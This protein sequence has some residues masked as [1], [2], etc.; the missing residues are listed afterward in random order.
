VTHQMMAARIAISI[1]VMALPPG[2]RQA[3]LTA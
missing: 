1:V 3:T 2:H